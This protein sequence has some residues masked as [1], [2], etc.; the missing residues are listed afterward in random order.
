MKS[1]SRAI[2]RFC[3]RNKNFGIRNLM[4]FIVIGTAAVWLFGM[5][6]TTGKFYGYLLF[7]PYDIL[8]GQVWRLVTF[9]FIPEADGVML[10]I[11]LYFYHFIGSSLEAEWG[12]AKFNLFYLCGTICNILFGFLL[13]FITGHDVFMSSNYINLSM[14]FAFAALF[15]ETRILLFFI[16]PIKVK[17]LALFDAAYFVVAIVR[18]SFP[19]NLLPV[20]AI[21]NFV[22]FCGYD[23][24]AAIMPQKAHFSGNSVN[25]RREARKI[26]H[27]QSRQEFRHQCAVCGRT[28]A[29]NPTLEFRYCSR[30]VG[31]RCYCEEHINSHVHFTE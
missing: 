20:V 27:E 3:G 29:S 19:E 17:W 21:L 23:L 16:I 8:R 15:P 26:R 6:D 31:Y 13:Y 4:V 28:D 12:T 24:F 30:C 10:L 22:L 5:M 9:L 14:F 2:N 11:F 25:F 1:L 18:T 7:S